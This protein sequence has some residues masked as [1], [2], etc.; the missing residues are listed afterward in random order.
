[1][2]IVAFGDSTTAG[3]P[4]YQSPV[5]APPDGEGDHTSQYAYWLV[6]KR[7]FWR[8]LNRG[9]NGERTDEIAERFDRDVAERRPYVVVVIAGVNDVFQNKPLDHIKTNLRKIYDRAA[10]EQIAVVAGSILPFNEATREQNA[11]MAK[12]NTW[13]KAEAQKD[14]NITFVDTRKA[15]ASKKSG[16]KLATT[17]DGQ[18]PDIAGYKKLA[19]AIEPVLA[20]VVEKSEASRRAAGSEEKK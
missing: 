9:V 10:E 4:L 12:V 18:H 1:M 6:E 19:A 16:N 11:K 7:P 15:V 3:T 2:L 8:V 17:A 20:K 14:R 5:E 13:I